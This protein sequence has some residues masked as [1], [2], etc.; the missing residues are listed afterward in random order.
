MSLSGPLWGGPASG[1]VARPL[2]ANNADQEPVESMTRAGLLLPA[3]GRTRRRGGGR[4]SRCRST[5]APRPGGPAR[6]SPCRRAGRRRCCAST[7]ATLGK[8]GVEGRLPFDPSHVAD[9]LLVRRGELAQPPDEGL[10]GGTVGGAP[11]EPD[12]QQRLVP[13]WAMGGGVRG[14]VIA[15][16]ASGRSRVHSSTAAHACRHRSCR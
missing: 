11:H 10:P 2:R 13:I 7:P 12:Q 14:V 3:R 1:T 6:R 16:I 15:V 9:L 8:E 5:S 4:R